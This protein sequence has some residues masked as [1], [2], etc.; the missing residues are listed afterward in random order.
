M[1][2]EEVWICLKTSHPTAGI[3]EN[4]SGFICPNV[5]QNLIF[6]EWE[7]QSLWQKRYDTQ[8]IARIPIEPAIREGGDSGKPIVYHKPDSQTAKIPRS[9]KQ[10]LGIYRK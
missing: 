5:K 1:I 4:M 10:T 9:I 2:V 8:V 7:Q 6:L 3:I